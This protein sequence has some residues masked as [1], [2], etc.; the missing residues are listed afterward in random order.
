[1]LKSFHC[2]KKE[3]KQLED[4]TSTTIYFA[5]LSFTF[6]FGLVS[7]SVENLYQYHG[8]SDWR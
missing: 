1:M 6:R 4:T 5:L 7:Q 3:K 2:G 8:I